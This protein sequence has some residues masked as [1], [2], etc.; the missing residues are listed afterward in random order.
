MA[1][2]AWRGRNSRGEEVSGIIEATSD[3][4]VADQLLAGG[5]SPV[6]IQPL[7]AADRASPDGAPATP[8]AWAA[9]FQRGVHGEDVLIL[10]RQLYTLQK[11]GVPL[12]RS[13]AGLQA[14]NG[15]PAVAELLGDV[16]ASLDQGRELSAALSRHATVFDAFYVAMIR[17]GEMTGRMPEVLLR[18]AEH[19]EFVLDTRERIKQALRYPTMVL[20]A[21]GVAMVVINLFVL[22][23]FAQVFA[24]FKTEL[25]LMTR[26]LLGS[27]DLMRAWW[28]LIGATLL[29]AGTLLRSW[30]ATPEGRYRWDRLQLRL[31][32]VG[33]IVLK[34]TLARFARSYAMAA[35][36]GVPVAQAMTVVSQ[37]VD[38]RYVGARVEQMRDSIERGESISRCAAAAGIFTPMVLQMIAV[39]E[40]TGAMDELMLEVADMYEREVDY[41]VKGLSGAIEPLL[42]LVIGSLVTVLALGV[43]LP[44]WNLGQAAMGH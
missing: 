42:L 3:H 26:L 38:N 7:R 5:L 27:S 33:P 6:D 9:L 20:A 32:I 12:L 39:G 19:T 24:G 15:K 16:R 11:S 1:S 18:L 41:A 4:G 13:L 29:A 37:T 35:T 10:T 22:P 30:L 17:V 25:P 36:S 23:V 40:E 21:I 31:P 34:A 44:L 8:P 43:F 2:F 28:P 14:S